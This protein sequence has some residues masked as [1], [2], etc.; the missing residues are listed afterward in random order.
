MPFLLEKNRGPCRLKL[1]YLGWLNFSYIEQNSD[2]CT[3]KKLVEKFLTAIGLK[4]DFFSSANLLF[5]VFIRTF[6]SFF[7]LDFFISLFFNFFQFFS[8]FSFFFQFFL[9]TYFS[10]S[11]QFFINSF[12][13][14]FHFFF[15]SIVVTFWISSK[16]FSQCK[17]TLGT[18]ISA[19]FTQCDQIFS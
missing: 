3:N 12:P 1:C 9:F 16:F 10:F 5:P 19:I 15:Y 11:F 17:E 4:N 13:T 6:I 18:R 7:Y 14:L 8:L 2:Y